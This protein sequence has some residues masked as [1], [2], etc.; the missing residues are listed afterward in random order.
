MPAKKRAKKDR[1]QQQQRRDQAGKFQHS[2]QGLAD[3][4][5]R[6]NAGRKGKPP[7]GHCPDCGGLAGNHKPECNHDAPP[8]GSMP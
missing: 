2:S 3:Q 4:V 6:N 1:T 5:A 8:D 7:V